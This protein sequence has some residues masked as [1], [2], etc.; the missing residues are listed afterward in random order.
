VSISGAEPR[1]L[2]ADFIR[3][4][5]GESTHIGCEHGVCGC[6]VL[7]MENCA[8]LLHFRLRSADPKLTKRGWREAAA[9]I[10]EAFENITAL[11]VGSVHLVLDH[12]V[13]CL[14]ENPDADLATIRRF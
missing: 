3:H 2:L 6:T 9:S 12:C 7:M 11:P 1:Y 10:Q 5:I 13:Q 4:E 8:Q 14:T